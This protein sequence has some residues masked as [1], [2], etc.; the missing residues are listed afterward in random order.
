MKWLKD[1]ADSV[2]TIAT[3]LGAVVWMNGKFTDIDH[4]FA[5]LEKDVAIIKTVLIMKD[6]LPKELATQ[7]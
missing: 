3:I 2:V 4:R 5:N 6:I 1:H 7:E